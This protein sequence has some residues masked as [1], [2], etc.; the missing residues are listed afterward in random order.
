MFERVYL[1]PSVRSEHAKVE[2]V[3]RTLFD[4]YCDHPDGLPGS[5]SLAERVTDYIAGMTDRY[6][7]ARFEALTVPRAF[8]VGG[9]AQDG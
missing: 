1:G 4:H 8:A 6:C 9:L 2:R 5:G 3:I 7:I